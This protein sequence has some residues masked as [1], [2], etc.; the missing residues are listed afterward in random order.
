MVPDP[1]VEGHLGIIA[2]PKVNRMKLKRESR[3]DRI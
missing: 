1:K 3:E 2:V